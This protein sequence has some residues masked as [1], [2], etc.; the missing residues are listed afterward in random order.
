MS[1]LFGKL[2]IRV[3]LC[4]VINKLLR[5]IK[6]NFAVIRTKK[7]LKPF[8]GSAIQK[9]ER[10]FSVC[11]QSKSMVISGELTS[12]HH[13]GNQLVQLKFLKTSIMKSWRG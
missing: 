2:K 9:T 6:L 10:K 11:R 8:N 1:H 12:A 7:W 13:V 3:Y 4:L 5:W